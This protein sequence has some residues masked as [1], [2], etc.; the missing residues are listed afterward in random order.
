M[1]GTVEPPLGAPPP[2]KKTKGAGKKAK[3]EKQTETGEWREKCIERFALQPL[4]QEWAS[5]KTLIELSKSND[6]TWKKYHDYRVEIYGGDKEEDEEDDDDCEDGDDGLEKRGNDE[7]GKVAA[8]VGFVPWAQHTKLSIIDTC[9]EDMDDLRSGTCLSSVF[10]PFVLPR[11]M[12]VSHRYIFFPPM[13][14][15]SD[16][17]NCS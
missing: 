11:A 15:V 1:G 4:P 10:S 6:R 5:N 9:W 16:T 3:S 13:F 7:L 2:R 17:T 8:E 12:T 14:L